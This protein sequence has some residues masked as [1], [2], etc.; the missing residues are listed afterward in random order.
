MRWR[1]HII[2]FT[3]HW[4]PCITIAPQYTCRTWLPARDASN[5]SQRPTSDAYGNYTIRYPPP[6]VITSV[7]AAAWCDT[8]PS[9]RGTG[10]PQQAFQLLHPAPSHAFPPRLKSSCKHFDSPHP[11]ITAS[12]AAA[13]QPPVRLFPPPRVLEKTFW[14]RFYTSAPG[15]P[16]VLCDPLASMPRRIHRLPADAHRCTGDQAEHAKGNSLCTAELSATQ[17]SALL[18]SVSRSIRHASA[19]HY[20]EVARRTDSHQFEYRWAVAEAL[21]TAAGTAHR[22]HFHGHSSLTLATARRGGLSVM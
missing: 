14:K 21:A 2:V 20:R 16:D 15:Q 1:S 7:C 13:Q 19:Q 6:Q 17:L 22:H 4:R 5:G 9:I 18:F 12:E 8:T 3:L 11:C 10:V